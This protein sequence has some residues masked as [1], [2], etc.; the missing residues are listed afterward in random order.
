[1]ENFYRGSQVFLVCSGPSLKDHDLSLL[2][3]R[4]IVTMAINNAWSVIRPNLWVCVD[5]P[6]NF[7]DVGWK[8]PSIIKF[9]PFG[10]LH[11]NLQVK[12]P[13]GSFRPSQFK[14]SDMP[15]VYYFRRNEKFEV[16]NFLHQNT[17]NWG[18]K[19]ADTDELGNKG[20]RSV[21]LAAIRLLYYLGFRR[22]YLLGVDFKM[23][24]GKQNYA[25]A[26]DRST[27]SI[28]GNNN[29]YNALNSR[30][31]AMSQ[32][33]EQ[34]DFKVFNC[35]PQSGLTAF[36]FM[37]YQQAIDAASSRFQ[38]DMDTEGWYDRKE[39]ERKA[40]ED[41]EKQNALKNVNGI[42]FGE[43]VEDPET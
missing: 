41:A 22:V 37:N 25:F 7:L 8:D 15:S 43:E 17:I 36:P 14:V 18:N 34:N 24:N 42:D 28:K 12:E 5:D 9:A 27:S 11:K 39:R 6:G 31:K 38:K 35:N 1:M 20:G 21:M 13:N 2:S 32:I 33:F 29:T 19:D 3:R 4:G 10:H 40:K 30:F 26:Q 23:E 16:N